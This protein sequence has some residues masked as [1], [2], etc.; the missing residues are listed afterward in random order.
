MAPGM[1]PVRITRWSTEFADGEAERTFRQWTWS[2]TVRQVRLSVAIASPAFMAFLY[3]DYLVLGL[4]SSFYIMLV[5]R[6]FL[7]LVLLGIFWATTRESRIELLDRAVVAGAFS[8]MLVMTISVAL[9]P[10]HHHSSMTTIIVVLGIYLFFFN[11]RF[12]YVA[13]VG[14]LGS[15]IYVVVASF[16]H[17][18]DIPELIVLVMSFA[19]VNLL[20]FG[21]VSHLNRLRRLEHASLTY[22]RHLEKEL[23]ASETLYRELVEGANSVILRFDTK[24]IIRFMNN[25]GLRFFGYEDDELVGQNIMGTIAPRTEQWE[26]ALAALMQD[27]QQHPER[28]LLAEAENMRKNGE[29]IWLTWSNRPI[30]NDKGELAEILSVGHDI[31]Q[32]KELEAELRRL[33]TTDP[34]TGIAN[35]RRFLDK[36]PREVTRSQRYGRNLSVLMLDVDHFK[37]INDRYGHA[38]G[39]QVL[40]RLVEVCTEELREHDVIGRLGGEEFAIL[41]PETELETARAVAERLR[42]NIE[43][44]TVDG[45]SFHFTVS[46]GV[47]QVKGSE[48]TAEEVIR[49]ADEALYRAKQKGR[50][51]VEVSG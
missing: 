24:G 14:M 28:Y 30:L 8:A 11:N 9:R 39:D 29:L 20:C 22:H 17:R 48:E 21:V 49:R 47:A 34:L 23:S 7:L 45:Q 35:R 26:S 31:S 42:Q 44:T 13:V 32:R 15:L 16:V 18:P 4:G 10:D 2:D 12:I 25:Y 6:C 41:L 3:P 46:F 37:S 51:R 19:L 36:A 50:N 38:V 43:R 1:K 5:A 40:C 27:V 33:A